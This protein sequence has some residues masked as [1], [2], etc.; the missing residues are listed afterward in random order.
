MTYPMNVSLRY[1]S[2]QKRARLY[3]H[4]T[5]VTCL[6]P[7]SGQGYGFEV[8]GSWITAEPS[9][10]GLAPS[11]GV[12]QLVSDLIGKDLDIRSFSIAPRE[13]HGRQNKLHSHKYQT[14]S[15]AYVG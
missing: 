14:L 2:K 4:N 11:A 7:F 6:F 13:F 15:L 1:R 10:F 12:E 8:F 5:I 3:M 9:A